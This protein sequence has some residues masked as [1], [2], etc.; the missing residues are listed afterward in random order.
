MSIDPSSRESATEPDPQDLLHPDL[1]AS[2]T[3]VPRHELNQ[4]FLSG[5]LFGAGTAA[6]VIGF[7]SGNKAL[8]YGFPAAYLLARLQGFIAGKL[9]DRRLEQLAGMPSSD[10]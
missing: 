10:A 1:R 2:W 9:S 7:V 6:S 4:I 8:W 3:V 5:F